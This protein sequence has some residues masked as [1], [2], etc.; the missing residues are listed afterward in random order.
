[1]GPSAP[2]LK[3]GWK[4]AC[5]A[6]RAP[7]HYAGLELRPVLRRSG[8]WVSAEAPGGWRRRIRCFGTVFPSQGCFAIRPAVRLRVTAE[9]VPECLEA[10]CL[11]RPR[12]VEGRPGRLR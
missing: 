7:A 6:V 10:G 1:M 5:G 9:R 4:G 2:L 12:P 11:V 3:G 8:V